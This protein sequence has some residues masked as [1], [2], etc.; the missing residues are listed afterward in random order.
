MH[1]LISEIQ[2]SLDRFQSLAAQLAKAAEQE[3]DPKIRLW[4]ARECDAIIL[5]AYQTEDTLSKL[6]ADLAGFS[7]RAAS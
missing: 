5:Q 2:A 7:D 3:N 6:W 1:D 4:L